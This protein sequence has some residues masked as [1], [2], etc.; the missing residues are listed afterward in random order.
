MLNTVQVMCILHCS[1]RR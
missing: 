1:D